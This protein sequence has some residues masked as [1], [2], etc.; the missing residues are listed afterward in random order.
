M[1]HPKLNVEFAA[2]SDVKGKFARLAKL[3]GLADADHARGKCEHLWMACTTRGETDL[4]RWLVEQILGQRGPEALVE[5]ELANW[6]RGRDSKTRRI[7]I[8]GA[9]KHCTWMAEK[10][11]QSSKA[12]KVNATTAIRVDGK[13][14]RKPTTGDTNT[15]RIT[16]SLERKHR[17]SMAEK[18][19]QTSKAGKVNEKTTIRAMASD[20]GEQTIE[21]HRSYPYPYPYPYPDPDPEIPTLL[22]TSV[23]GQPPVPTPEIARARKRRLDPGWIPAASETNRIAEAKARDRGVDLAE[24]L[25]KLHD[26]ALDGAKTGA[27]WDARWRNWLRNSRGGKPVGSPVLGN[28]LEEISRREKAGEK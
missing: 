8:S 4:P 26:W 21:N 3:L 17:T 13:F 25:K 10:E 15:P 24:E 19:E 18:E 23:G 28:L 16:L 9:S 22:R 11:A 2:V 6:G 1:A 27:D 20:G 14:A 5:A 7:S 12:G